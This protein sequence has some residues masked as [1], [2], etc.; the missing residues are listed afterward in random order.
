MCA[1]QIQ[2]NEHTATFKLDTET[3]SYL[4]KIMEGGFLTHLYYGSRLAD[5]HLDYVLFNIKRSLTTN[6]P[7]A[8]GRKSF[9]LDMFPMEY[10]TYGTGGLPAPAP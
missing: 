4:I 7:E 9:S 3:T 2:F 5:D 10:P 1:I 6:P 8:Y